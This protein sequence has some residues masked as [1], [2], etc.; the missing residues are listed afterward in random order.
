MKE[1]SVLRSYTL[2]S[3]EQMVNHYLA[4]G[5]LLQG[6]I[7]A[8]ANPEKSKSSMYPFIYFQAI[9]LPT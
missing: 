7:C 8:I 2:T 1:Y 3:L 9:Y 6:G 5:Y 4:K